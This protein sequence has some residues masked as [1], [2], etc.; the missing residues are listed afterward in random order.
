[1]PDSVMTLFPNVLRSFEAMKFPLQTT[2]AI[3]QTQIQSVTT[4][5]DIFKNTQ[6]LAYNLTRRYTNLVIPGLHQS[7]AIPMKLYQEGISSLLDLYKE[8]FLGHL[9]RFHQNRAGE[10]EFIKLFTDQYEHQD[11]SVEYDPSNI[12]ID[13]PGMRV[14]DISADV[15]HRIHNYGVVFAP[16]A[17][18]HSNIAERVALFLRDQGVTR[19]AVVEQKCAEEIPLFVEGNRHLEDFKGQ[20]D[21]YRRVLELL[22]KRTGYPPH[23]IA[24]CQPGPLLLSTLILHPELSKTFGSAGSP[25]NTEAERGFLTDFARMAGEAFID[26]LIALFGRT[27]E[28]D[29]PGAGRTC[30]DGRLQVLGFYLLAWDQHLKNLKNL[31]ADL[32]KGD[33][34]A[35]ERQKTFYQWYNTVHHF[36]VDFIR[37][38]YKKIFIQNALINGGLRIGNKTV[39]IDDYPSHVP[40]WALG[41]T[42]DNIAPPLQAVGHLDLISVK[43]L[44]NKLRL[45]CDAGHM[46]LFRSQRILKKYYN[47]VADFLLTHSDYTNRKF[48]Y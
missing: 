11:W 40:I 38:T 3:N 34:K 15:R 37:D 29:H 36:P 39:K 20:I 46:G 9:N 23:L 28:P 43:P 32:K 16:R 19:M 48:W 8:I 7:R 42:A 30:Y 22:K 33:N 6:E 4:G 2:L 44:Q 25:M 45:I 12:L 14:I 26:Q 24:I 47:R 35:A 41:G 10:L 31:L 13:L 1:M 5:F 17:G 27:I 21:Q 18:H